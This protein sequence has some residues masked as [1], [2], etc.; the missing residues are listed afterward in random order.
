MTIFDKKPEGGA[1]SIVCSPSGPV[2]RRK[3][4]GRR[5]SWSTEDKLAIVAEV[6]LPGETVAT[7][8]RRHDMNA[9]HLLRWMGRAKEGTLARRMKRADKISDAVADGGFIDLGTFGRD[10]IEAMFGGGG[11][12]EIELPGPMRVKL[13]LSMPPGQLTNIVRALKAA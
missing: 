8:A 1:G 12:I 4:V 6:D 10:T 7:V 3:E 11:A 5:R 2:S 13:P 9:D